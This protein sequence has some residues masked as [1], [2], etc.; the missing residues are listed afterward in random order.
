MNKN[1]R[2]IM[3]FLWILVLLLAT[4]ALT[5]SVING[6][7]RNIIVFAIVVIISAS[8]YLFRRNQRIKK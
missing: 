2:I 7:T 1:F 8:M 3:E 4:G 5:V 6:D